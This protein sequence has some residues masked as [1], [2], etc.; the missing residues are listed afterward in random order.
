MRA[1]WYEKQGSAREV[2]VVGEM[3][4]PH[5]G[6]G[7]VRIRIAASSINPFYIKKRQDAF[8]YGMAYPRIIPHGDGAGQVDQV[9]EASLPNGSA[10]RCGVTAHNPIDR[11][12]QL[13]SLPWFRSITLLRCP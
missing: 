11:S 10:G 4:D 12:A 7:E 8:G 3:P 2:L 9:G 1:A 6:A 13:R 5:P